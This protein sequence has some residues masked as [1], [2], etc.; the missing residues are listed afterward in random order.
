M[1]AVGA[2]L[3]AIE[4]MLLLG[5]NVLDIGLMGIASPEQL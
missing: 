5:P 2:N 3:H 4:Q 1:S